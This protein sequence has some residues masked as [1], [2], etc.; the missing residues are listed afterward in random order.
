VREDG[1]RAVAEIVHVSTKGRAPKNDPALYA[2]AIAA[3]LGDVETRRAALEA[4]PQV[5][6]TGTH[7]FQF[8]Y[9]S[10]AFAAG[11]ARFAVR[12]VW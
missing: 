1:P 6:R 11:V 3:R 5:A 2:L 9:S 7:L 8:A 10:W 12:S 4:L